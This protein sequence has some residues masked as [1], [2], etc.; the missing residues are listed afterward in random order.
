MIE[1]AP[2][3]PLD[4]REIPLDEIAA[5]P[6]QPRVEFDDQKL[7]ELRNSIATVGVLE[8]ILV[9]EIALH[10]DG[11]GSYQLI[12]GER[13]LRAAKLA[14]LKTIPASVRKLDERAAQEIAIVENLQREDLS[15]IEE[16]RGYESL[17]AWPDSPI[18]RELASRLGVSQSHIANRLRL[19]RLPERWQKRVISGEITAGHARAL[20]PYAEVPEVLAAVEKEI[21]G[22]LKRGGLPNAEEFRDEL[23][24]EAVQSVSRPMQG[25]TYSRDTW[26]DEPIFRPTEEER[27]KLRI[28]ELPATS[29][30]RYRAGGGRGRK[31]AE[32]ER[33]AL[34]VKLWDK[35][36][37]A[38]VA[39]LKATRESRGAKAKGK[40]AGGNGEPVPP[41]KE[42]LARR[43]KQQAAQFRRR[44]EEVAID[45]L[46]YLV[47]RRILGGPYG[48]EEYPLLSADDQLRLVLLMAADQA[49]WPG[50]F[51]EDRR[52][53]LA[54]LLKGR[55]I[56]ASRRMGQLDC[57]AGI[58]GLGDADVGPV[59]AHWLAKQ[60]WGWLP[61]SKAE[62]GLEA[63]PSVPGYYVVEIAR[64]LAV[65]PAKAWRREQMG[66]ELSRR[67]WEI[68]TRDQLGKLGK[69]LK[70]ELPATKAAAVDELQAAEGLKLPKELAGW[71]K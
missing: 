30:S 29:S 21:A 50:T 19:L 23:V 26:R 18:Q 5:A 43:R 15:P 66:P 48:A 24:D 69:E 42:E 70:I 46:R 27:E 16:A 33:R 28:V 49:T 17:L 54:E 13:R 52:S 39:Q 57:W 51:A 65:E 67:Y 53:E 71:C 34:N 31:P 3:E 36:Q 68:H 6:W 40:A 45:W 38:R 63:N 4:V 9:R 64:T 61:R 60:F 1:P 41:T 20:V 44:L 14:H 35:L 32:T 58:A 2:A 12:A 47:H 37:A 11:S 7:L 10:A 55:G 8:P 59:A 22:E 25:T 62:D 56:A